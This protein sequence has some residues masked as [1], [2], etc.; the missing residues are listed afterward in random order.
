M[1]EMKHIACMKQMRN[2]CRVL[3]EYSQGKRPLGR[4]KHKWENSIKMNIRERV[5]ED[6]K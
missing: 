4:G 5:C 3:N 6:I 1:R 2:A